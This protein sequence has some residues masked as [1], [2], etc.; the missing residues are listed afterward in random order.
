MKTIFSIAALV[1]IA[2]VVGDQ[3]A[4][5]TV[6]VPPGGDLQTALNSA[7]PGDTILLTRDGAYLGN[8]VLPAPRGS[9]GHDDGVITLRTEGDD[10]PREDERM[11][12]AAAEHLAKLQSPNGSP[13]L[14]TAPGARGWHIALLE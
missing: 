9:A 7:R 10:W 6:R 8:F 12:P 4:D 11:T 1:L 14:H 13:V 5:S 3:S 2:W